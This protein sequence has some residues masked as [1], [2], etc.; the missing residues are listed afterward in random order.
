MRIKLWLTV[1]AIIYNVRVS[2]ASAALGGR[3][4]H[5]QWLSSG[6]ENKCA[7]FSHTSPNWG[8]QW[9]RLAPCYIFRKHTM[10]VLVLREIWQ[11]PAWYCSVGSFCIQALMVNTEGFRC[12]TRG[13]IKNTLFQRNKNTMKFA[14]GWKEWDGLE[15]GKQH[16]DFWFVY[17]ITIMS[18]DVAS[19]VCT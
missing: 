15:D 14:I 13:R 6:H 19:Y 7:F 16:G 10:V 17:K 4:L 5:E 2:D 11:R 18:G 1:M 9:N 8:W 12:K 3:C